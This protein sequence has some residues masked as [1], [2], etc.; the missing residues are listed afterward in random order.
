MLTPR[1]IHEAEFHVVFRGYSEK[2]VDDFLARVVNEYEALFQ[3]NKALKDQVEHLRH[4]I[5]VYQQNEVKVRE[6]LEETQALAAELKAGAERHSRLLL[7]SARERAER[8]I[9][10]AQ[11]EASRLKAQ[12]ESEAELRL[13]EAQ[14]KVEET[15]RQLAA[16]VHQWQAAL[17]DLIQEGAN[18]RKSLQQLA[19]SIAELVQSV[20]LQES[21]LAKE[22][23]ELSADRFWQK[24]ESASGSGLVA[25]GGAGD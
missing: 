12:A 4:Q 23:R 13:A 16:T 1:D 21:A 19:A 24:R 8:I 11:E 14:T 15:K 22:I 17:L 25:P 7:E 20:T 6:M 9:Q 18:Y 5:T 3:E 2:E 10:E